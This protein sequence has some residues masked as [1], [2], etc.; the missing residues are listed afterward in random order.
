VRRLAGDGA[1]RK[2]LLVSVHVARRVG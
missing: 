1:I 2:H